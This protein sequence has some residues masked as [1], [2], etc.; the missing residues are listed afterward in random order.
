MQA[1]STV[2]CTA[3]PGAR[4]RQGARVYQTRRCVGFP[5]P[6][7]N[8]CIWPRPQAESVVTQTRQQMQAHSPSGGFL[9]TCSA[10]AGQREQLMQCGLLAANLQQ[11]QKCGGFGA[12]CAVCHARSQTPAVYSDE[13]ICNAA[14]RTANPG[15]ISVT[16]R[17]CT[18]RGGAQVFQTRWVPG[19]FG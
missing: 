5:D 11:K 12:G 4:F 14:R 17:R 19:V 2:I 1:A 3:N 15:G 9:L 7:G 10:L 18:R 6:M 16:R 13:L 8:W